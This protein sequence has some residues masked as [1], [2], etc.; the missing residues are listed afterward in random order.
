VSEREE[1]TGSWK[2]MGDDGLKK[3]AIF[4]IQY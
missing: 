3:F 1:A 2:T 4:A